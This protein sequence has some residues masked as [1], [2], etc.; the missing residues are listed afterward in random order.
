[1]SPLPITPKPDGVLL[2]GFTSFY[3]GVNVPI[4]EMQ[5]W[6]PQKIT[7]F[8]AGIAKVVYARDDRNWQRRN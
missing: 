6:S 1:M 2:D 3:I 8:F 5:H 4:E 7:D